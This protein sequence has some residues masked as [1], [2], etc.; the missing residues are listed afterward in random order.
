[1]I[2]LTTALACEAK[3]LVDFYRLKKE[4]ASNAFPCYRSEE[5]GLVVSG[6]GRIAMAAATAYLGAYYRANAGISIWLNVGVA[7]H[8]TLEPGSAVLVDKVTEHGTTKHW[9]PLFVK[10]PALPSCSLTTV[11]TPEK[12]YVMQTLYDMEGSAFIETAARFTHFEFVHLYKVVSDNADSGI[13]HINKQFVSQVIENKTEEIDQLIQALK[14]QREQVVDVYPD[15]L[16]YERLLKQASFSFSQQQQLK[17]LLQRFY[18]LNNAEKL[19]NII[20]MD[21]DSSKCFL[22][23]LTRLVERLALESDGR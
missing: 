1:M 17:R 11:D 18:S 15:H 20:N 14:K 16:D 9:Y 6:M 5:M 22:Q 7:G 4:T 10:M 3:P 8:S 12:T 21:V 19:E 13:A 2:Y 23:E